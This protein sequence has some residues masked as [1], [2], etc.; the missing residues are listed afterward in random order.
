MIG[1]AN[2]AFSLASKF[3]VRWKDLPMRTSLQ[4][5]AKNSVSH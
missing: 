2:L 1:E 4:G 5:T 3:T